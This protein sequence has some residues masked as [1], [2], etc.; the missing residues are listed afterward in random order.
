MKARIG[1]FY[2]GDVRHNQDIATQNHQKLF[3][4]LQELVS[5]HV[6][7][8]TRD[9]PKRGICPYDP[10]QG[11]PN[12]VVYRRGQGGAVQVWDFL[13][14]VQRT[15]EEIILRIRT[16]V[17]FTDTSIDLIYFELNEM[18]H[19]RSGIAYFGSDW[20]N[21]VAGTVNERLEVHIDVDAVIQ[22]F[23]ILARR[24]KLKSFD[25]TIEDLNKVVPNKR[26]S[27]NKTFRYIIP[28]ENGVPGFRKQL[29]TVHRVLCQIWLIRKTYTEYPD[30]MEVCKDYIQSYIVDDKAKAGKKNLIDPHPMTDAVNWWRAQQGWASTEIKI[31]EW[32]AWQKQ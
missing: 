12:D 8:F 23:V 5:V 30:D 16:D 31:G 4:R 26:R 15:T 14:G 22:D 21:K 27:G 10:P 24:D 18:I 29:A 7:R 20:V 6:Y 11:D 19:N 25:D 1:I 32:W 3:D 17:W 28:I 13:R 2:T 9:D